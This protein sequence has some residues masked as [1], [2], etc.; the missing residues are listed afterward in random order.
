M[1][2]NNKWTEES[3]YSTSEEEEA[4]P[5]LSIRLLN[6]AMPTLC[7]LVHY[8]LEF[9]IHLTTAAWVSAATRA[10]SHDLLFCSFHMKNYWLRCEFLESR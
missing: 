9:S 10:K 1:Y 2:A 8:Y 4:P 6:L 3:R 5:F 7:G